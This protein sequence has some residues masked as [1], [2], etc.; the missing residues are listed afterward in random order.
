MYDLSVLIPAKNEEWLGRTVQDLLEN[1]EGNTEV[2]VVLDG[3]DRPIPDIPVDRRVT[4]LKNEV[5]V[6]Q[7]AAS[8]QACRASEAAYVMKV[9]AHCAFSKGFDIQLISAMQG[10]DNW[11]VIPVMRNLHVFNWVCTNGHSRYQ[12]LSGVCKECGAETHKEVVWIAK[13]SPQSASFCFDSEPHFQYFGEYTKR[14]EYREMLAATGLTETMSIQGSSFMLTREKYW[15]LNI[16][17][18]EF[19]SWGSQGIEVASKTWLSGG[20]VMCCHG[21]WYSHLFRT[22]GGDFG[23]PYENKESDKERAKAIA[24]DMFFRSKWD[25]A[26]YPLSWLV[27]RFWPVK[28]WTEED[29]ANLKLK[30]KH[31]SKGMI[32]YTDSRLDEKVAKPVRDQLAGISIENKIPLVVSSLKKLNFGTKDIHYPSWKRGYVTMTKQILSA[33]ENLD[34]DIVFFTEHD[35]LYHPSHFEFTPPRKDIFYYN[36]NVWKIRMSDGHAIYVDDCKQVSGIC[37][38]RDLAIS[39]YVKRLAILEDKERTLSPEEFNKFMREMGFEPGTHGRPE[40]V[41]DLKSEGYKSEYPNVDIRHDS[42]LTPSRWNKDQFKN[43]R[44]TRGWTESDGYNIPGW[45][46]LKSLLNA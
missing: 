14:P 28:G 19:G 13:N 34:S 5:S 33:L 30:E 20:K 32:Y 11:T 26:I 24:K 16:C 45:P 39:H 2:I 8:N 31:L 7:R 1:I 4:V 36:T 40:R 22:Q 35:V 38:Y 3:Y 9:D 27:E 43:E 25:K 23:F 44:F 21:C 46:D 42:T 10:H 41:D 18:E 12:G 37:V 15:E 6:G 29:L 17:G